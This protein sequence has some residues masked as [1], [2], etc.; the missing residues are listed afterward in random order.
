MSS[1]V[2][3]GEK[4]I[5]TLYGKAVNTFSLPK[6]MYELSREEN[7]LKQFWKNNGKGTDQ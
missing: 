4:N 7:Q 1:N 2:Q 6:I 5:K 3:N